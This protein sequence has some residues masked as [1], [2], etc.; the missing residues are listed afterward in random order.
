VKLSISSLAWTSG[1]SR[2][3]HK[4]LL[5]SNIRHIDTV[6]LH[7]V[8]SLETPYDSELQHFKNFWIS[9]GFKILGLQSLF[10]EK[11]ALCFFED[12]ASC[13]MAI[14]YFK[15]I[16]T[17]SQKLGVNVLVFGSPKQRYMFEKREK[18]VEYFFRSLSHAC[19][20]SDLFLCIESNSTEYGTNFLT[21]TH[22]TANFVSNLGQKNIMMNF[23]TGCDI[24]N[25]QDPV[26]SFEKYHKFVGHVHLS[27]P[28]LGPVNSKTL[29]HSAMFKS[30]KRCDFRG[31]VTIEMMRDSSDEKS[32]ENVKDAIQVLQTYYM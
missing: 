19:E 22:E 32:I 2:D 10:Y 14:S 7:V 30:L 20:T 5:E 16:V 11:N 29:D 12:N 17:L 4:I 1:Q 9:S 8:R 6:P 13:E 31:G 24:M 27:S 21:S 23:D 3:V 18:I 25:N 15:R 26:E 28:Y